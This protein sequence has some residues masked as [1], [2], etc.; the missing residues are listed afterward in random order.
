MT[1]A[2]FVHR[3]VGHNLIADGG[4]YELVKAADP[5]L[6]LNDYDQN[7]DTLTDSQ[8][9]QKQLGFIFPDGNTKPEDYAQIFSD[10]VESA[11]RPILDLAMGYDTIV[12]KSCYP[13]SNIKTDEELE[14]VKSY[15][16]A[17]AAFFKS[18]SSKQLLILT[19][20]PLTPLMT[21]QKAAARARQ[22]A[23]WLA[24]ID[25]GDNVRVFNLFDLLAAPEG[26]RQAN[27]LR[28]NYRRWLPVDSH[29]NP[30]ASQE[31]APLLAEFIRTVRTN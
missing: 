13:N 1:R 21:N 26:E 19:S 10:Q 15:Y 6:E 27:R 17:I 20:P 29:P 25:L 28:K 31:I 4:V 8:G 2:L 16:Q 23:T 5:Q 12:I 11:Y 7:T 9:Q 22:L 3:S 18:R 30:K 14:A 24:S